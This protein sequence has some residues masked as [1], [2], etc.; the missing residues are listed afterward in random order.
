MHHHVKKV[1]TLY[2]CEGHM[3]VFLEGPRGEPVPH[4]MEPGTVITLQ[5]YQWHRFSN[6]S[7]H[8]PAVLFEVGTQH[9][10][11]DSIRRGDTDDA[12]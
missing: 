11:D 1:E 2:L 6:A 7:E 9:F 4:I 12:A 8:Q 10:D 5:P 3:M